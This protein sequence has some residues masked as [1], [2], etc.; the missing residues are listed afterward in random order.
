MKKIFKVLFSIFLC[1]TCFAAFLLFGAFSCEKKKTLNDF[2]SELRTDVFE[3]SSDNYS[4]KA[5]YGFKETPYINDGVIGEKVYSLSFVLTNKLADDVKRTIVFSF[6]QEEYRADFKF[7]PSSD[8]FTAGAEINEFNLKD[9]PVK[10]IAGS[11]AEEVRL[12]SVVPPTAITCDKALE[13][14]SSEQ[15]A[16]IETYKNENGEFSGEISER[17]II[18]NEKPY[19]YVGL[20]NGKGGT[21]ALLIDGLNGEILAVREII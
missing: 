14:L 7:N 6:N 9:F 10:I 5:A 15:G 4:L 3:G 21:K 13:I 2:V 18:K 17:I 1:L 8:S 20:L 12:R 11:E 16:L 19:W